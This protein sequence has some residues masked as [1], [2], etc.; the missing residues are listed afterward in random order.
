MT[1]RHASEDDPAIDRTDAVAELS[2]AFARYE[3]ALVAND[4]VV[5][6]ELF[7]DD[8]RTLRYGVSEN[9]YGI[10]AIRAFR[11][12]RPAAGLGRTTLRTHVTTYGNTCATT[13]IE[14]RRDGNARIGRQTQTWVRFA[15]HGWRVVSA[16]VSLMA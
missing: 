7:W 6:D 14:F 8:A 5:L 4:T 10:E 3:A 11:N 1:I 13:A 2:A 16:H 12:A 9:L 15:A